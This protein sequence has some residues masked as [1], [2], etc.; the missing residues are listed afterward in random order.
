M[1]SKLE[2]AFGR[3]NRV[4]QEIY[5]KVERFEKQKDKDFDDGSRVTYKNGIVDVY[6]K[7]KSQRESIMAAKHSRKRH[8]QKLQPIADALEPPII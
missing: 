3:E 1:H 7:A 6:T 8:N 4:L 2:S 5:K